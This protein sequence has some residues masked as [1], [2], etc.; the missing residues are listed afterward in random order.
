MLLWCAAHYGAVGGWMLVGVNEP[1]TVAV[2]SY[3]ASTAAQTRHVNLS[4]RV[5]G[6]SDV[7]VSGTP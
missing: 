5:V 7:G 1:D 3:R 2:E 6:C 4:G